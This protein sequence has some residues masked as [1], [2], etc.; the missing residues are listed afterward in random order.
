MIA[1]VIRESPF[2]SHTPKQIANQL[3]LDIQ[4]VTSIV[5]RL[6]S[7]GVIERI[8]WGKYIQKREQEFE[9]TYLIDIIHDMRE[10]ASVILGRTSPLDNIQG[11]DDP[12]KELMEVYRSIK[13]LGGEAMASNLLRL[14]AKKSMLRDK[15]DMLIE[16]FEEVS[17][18]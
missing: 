15:V 11:Q 14:C 1:R 6:R 9:D 13:E 16:S 18:Q 17:E 7:E 3:D 12:F 4:L 5:N 2:Q 8:G 10:M